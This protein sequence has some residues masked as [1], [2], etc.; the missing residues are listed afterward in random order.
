MTKS[1]SS[2]DAS[3]LKSV[4]KEMRAE[5]PSKKRQ[6]R[7]EDLSF[8]RKDHQVRRLAGRRTFIITSAQNNTELNLAFWKA[9]QNFAKERSAQIVVIPVRY[10]NPT[11]RRDP[12]EERDDRYWWPDDVKPFLV[13]NEIE[14]HDHLRIMAHVRIQATESNPLSGIEE[15][16]QDA[17]AIYGHGQLQ[18]KTVATP[19]LMLPKILY[20][21]GSVS[22]SNYSS[23][24]RAAKS[25][26]HHVNSAVIVEVRGKR[27]HP[28]EVTWSR[29]SRSFIDYHQEFT[30]DKVRRAPRP[31]A[32]ITGDS[33]AVFHDRGVEL[34]T[35]T[36]SQA[37]VKH[38]R[39]RTIVR[40]D[41][42]DGY[43]ICP[44]HRGNHL[45][46]AFKA[47]HPLGSAEYELEQT[48]KFLL[49]TSGGVENV[50]VASNHDE[51][52]RRWVLDSGSRPFEGRN[53]VLWHQLNL[54]LLLEAR[55]TAGG[56]KYPDPFISWMKDRLSKDERG[57]LFKFLSRDESYMIGDFECGLH[58]D[59]GVNGSRGSS[60]QFSKIGPKTITGHPHAPCIEKGCRQVGT[61][62]NLRLEYTVGPS[63]W[64]N[65]HSLVHDNGE[66]QMIHIID[67]RPVGFKL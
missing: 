4:E 58:G 67:G 34:A 33:H 41:V 43:S 28:R 9:I 11:S 47:N 31:K 29:K 1:K 36:G 54:K 6:T 63:S 64:L 46:S 50:I 3:T 5:K 15:L 17:S 44:H 42:H 56:L 59:K 49:R 12:M 65:T 13:E 62:S 45:L 24:K 18:M 57:V 22:Q 35:F 23:T 27:F 52:L 2:G 48:A 14:V 61:S 19:N 8:E 39:P 66:S 38:L 20:T 26:F 40:H 60:R 30:A 10:K 25:E 7:L 16:S 51:F 53:A 32:L 55:M 21:T 37:I